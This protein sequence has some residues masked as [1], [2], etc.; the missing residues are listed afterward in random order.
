MRKHSFKLVTIAASALLGL[1]Q[2]QAAT[3]TSSLSVSAT[4][5]ADCSIDTVNTLAFSSFSGLTSLNQDQTTT[6]DITCTNTTPY[7]I[8]L[9][10]GG[11][12]GATVANRLM[13]N[14]TDT[15]AYSI[16]SNSARTTVWGDTVG[17]NTV[18]STGTGSSQTHT[19]YGRVFASGLTAV[20][21][22]TYSDTVTV[23]VTF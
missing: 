10:A 3:T 14:G 11:G 1:T 8:G 21:P 23:T 18:A 22:K 13:V 17:T 6:I 9:S 16:Y 5:T 7:D 20:I 19:L 12:T 2:A 4:V 15:I